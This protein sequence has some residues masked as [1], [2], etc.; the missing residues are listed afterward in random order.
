MKFKD[1]LKQSKLDF[2]QDPNKTLAAI[3]DIK[4][5]I[6]EKEIKFNYWK[7]SYSYKTMRGNKKEKYSYVVAGNKEDAEFSFTDHISEFN[8]R[9]PYRALLNVKI[10][11]CTLYGSSKLTLN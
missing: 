5:K 2:F 11:K 4:L 1:I 3:E 8:K 9:Y 7:V 6:I 10:L